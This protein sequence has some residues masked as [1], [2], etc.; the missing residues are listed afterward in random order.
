MD[1]KDLYIKATLTFTAIGVQ[2]FAVCL[3][4]D[5]KP[6]LDRADSVAFSTCQQTS[7]VFHGVRHHVRAT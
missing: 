5:L 2:Q 3:S 4:V 7:E 1:P 6:L